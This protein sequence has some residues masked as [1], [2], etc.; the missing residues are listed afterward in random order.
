MKKRRRRARGA[1]GCVNFV[2]PFSQAFTLNCK[3]LELTGMSCSQLYVAVVK[4]TNPKEL[5]GKYKSEA[6]KKPLLHVQQQQ[7]LTQP[8]PDLNQC[9]SGAALSRLDR[10]GKLL[11]YDTSSSGASISTPALTQHGHSDFAEPVPASG[12]IL[13]SVYG[14]INIMH[15]FTDLRG[16]GESPKTSAKSRVQEG[17]YWPPQV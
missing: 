2:L 16:D 3:S 4:H 12:P 10:K 6:H 17:V 15:H 14:Q 8:H 1:Y 9:L 5:M 13:W 11:I 7:R